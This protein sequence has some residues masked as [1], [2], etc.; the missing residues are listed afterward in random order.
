M[1]KTLSIILIA[2][3]AASSAIGVSAAVTNGLS[4]NS[5]STPD[6][7][8]VSETAASPKA[9]T[10]TQTADD[11][12]DL[13][14]VTGTWKRVDDNGSSVQ[15]VKQEGNQLDIVIE[16]HNADY[17]KIATS[18]LRLTLDTYKDEKGAFGIAHFN[19][20]DSFGS[21]GR[22]SIVVYKDRIEIKLSKEFDPGAAW[23]ISGASGEYYLDSKNVNPNEA[24]KFDNL[25]ENQQI[26]DFDVK[27]PFMEGLWKHTEKD[28][29]S[30]QV[31]NQDGNKADLVL[32]CSNENYS[33][34]ATAKFSVEF[35]SYTTDNGIMSS[36]EFKYTDSFGSTGTGTITCDG[37]HMHLEL[38]PDT[39]GPWSIAPMSGD[40]T[41]A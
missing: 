10:A 34:I 39:N 5:T 37:V 1:K 21:G 23:N 41:M 14:N 18:R 3:I 16:S 15:V 4:T 19:Y 26:T 8:Q 24:D 33:K 31:L 40:Y 20:T 6:S 17:S 13:P 30:V 32:E 25:P 22:G 29:A 2:A 35:T 38:K 9:A 11:T 12:T 28:H 7:V 36:A 27:A